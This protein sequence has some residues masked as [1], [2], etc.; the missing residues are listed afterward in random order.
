[1]AAAAPVTVAGAGLVG[2][3]MAVTLQQAGY[4]VTLYERYEVGM[5]AELNGPAWILLVP[6]WDLNGT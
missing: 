6:E 5:R 2:S 1:M 3:L 4:D